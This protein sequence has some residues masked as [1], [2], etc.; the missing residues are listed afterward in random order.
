MSMFPVSSR[1]FERD[2]S[3]HSKMTWYI[4]QDCYNENVLLFSIFLT[5]LY[6]VKFT[7]SGRFVGLLGL[8]VGPVH[9][10]GLRR[11]HL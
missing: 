10:P 6:S 9:N 8:S 3:L 1:S 7:V 2:S 5:A 4:F 11:C